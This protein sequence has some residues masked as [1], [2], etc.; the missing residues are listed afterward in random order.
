MPA[1]FVIVLISGI[2]KHV[3]FKYYVDDFM[4]K[5]GPYYILVPIS[6]M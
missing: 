6:G 3:S 5:C 1:Y 2:S 4:K